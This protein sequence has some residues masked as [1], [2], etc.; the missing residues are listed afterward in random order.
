MFSERILNNKNQE[1]FWPLSEEISHFK[2]RALAVGSYKKWGLS[3]NFFFIK[4]TKI[5]TGDQILLYWFEDINS[6]GP[7]EKTLLDL[8]SQLVGSVPLKQTQDL[9]FRDFDYFLRDRNSESPFDK[10]FNI[11]I[12]QTIFMEV[13]RE[14]KTLLN[15]MWQLIADSQ[16]EEKVQFFLDWIREQPTMPRNLVPLSFEEERVKFLAKK[17]LT[18]GETDGLLYTQNRWRE[19]CGKKNFLFLLQPLGEDR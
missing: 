13:N 2:G 4:E 11:A 8:L 14:L 19:L 16:Y 18:T 7:L 10:N 6:I 9:S 15:P 12:L 17:Q 1:K 3:L 5:D